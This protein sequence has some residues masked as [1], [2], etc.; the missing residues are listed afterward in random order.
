[1]KIEKRSLQQPGLR[2]SWWTR[3]KRLYRI[4]WACHH[5]C[6][7]FIVESSISAKHHEF[8]LLS[9]FHPDNGRDMRSKAM[10]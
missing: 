3:A 2:P 6:Q 1:L 8:G 4:G 7:K 5:L 9:P 10:E